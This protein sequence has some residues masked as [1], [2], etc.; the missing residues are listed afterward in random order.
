[1]ANRTKYGKLFSGGQG[2]RVDDIFNTVK[3]QVFFTPAEIDL[4]IMGIEP[5]KLR[6]R[7]SLERVY[8]K[9]DLQFTRIVVEKATRF[10]KSENNDRVMNGQDVVSAQEFEERFLELK[11]DVSTTV[12]SILSATHGFKYEKTIL[13]LDEYVPRAPCSIPPGLP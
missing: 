13:V 8:K 9:D 12:N 3:L 7:K 2:V 5:R 1:L 10:T 6:A 4:W 11:T